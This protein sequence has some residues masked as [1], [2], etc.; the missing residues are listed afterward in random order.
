M[1]TFAISS[2]EL[3][4]HDLKM[5]GRSVFERIADSRLKIMLILVLF[6]Y[7]LFK[8]YFIFLLY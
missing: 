8:I 6:I 2:S 1:V 5:S 7:L 3:V 4:G